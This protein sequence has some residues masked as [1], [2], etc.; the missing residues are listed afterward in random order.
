MSLNH[1]INAD[2]PYT[3]DDDQK[4][5]IDVGDVKCKYL[6]V[7]SQTSGK[8]IGGTT[9]TFENPAVMSGNSSQLLWLKGYQPDYT[10]YLKL[11]TTFNAPIAS[12]SWYVEITNPI[13]SYVGNFDTVLFGNM[14]T[15]TPN[16]AVHMVKNI[17]W[18][19][20]NTVRIHFQ[21][22]DG[23]NIVPATFNGWVKFII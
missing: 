23:S 7:A 20:T 17:N 12:N 2:D 8:T 5:N 1:L 15:D 11:S 18:V 19:T 4:L 6:T 16:I 14:N 9:L 10:Y 13:I 22:A 3:Y 21:T